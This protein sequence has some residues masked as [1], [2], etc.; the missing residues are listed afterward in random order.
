MNHTQEQSRKLLIIGLDCADPHLVF[1]QFSDLLPVFRSIADRGFAARLRSTDPPLTIPAWATMTT[2]MN[3]GT[4][5]C[6]GLRNRTSYQY[7]SLEISTSQSIHYPRIWNRLAQTGRQSIIVGV[8]QTYPV[9]PMNGTLIAG[10][11]APDIHSQFT[12]PPDLKTD[13]LNR[14]PDYQIDIADFRSIPPEALQSQII[15]M[16]ETRFAALRY[17]LQSR[18]WD[19]A[20]MVEIAL[21]RLHHAFWHY[22]DQTHPLHPGDTALARVLPD[23]YRL[24]NREIEETLAILPDNTDIMIVSDHG[25]QPMRGGFRINEWLRQN[26]Y[27][28]LLTGPTRET[29]LSADMVDWSQTRAWGEGGYF[30]RIFL[31]VAGREPQGIIA[32]AEYETIRQQLASSLKS[33]YEPSEYHCGPGEMM[34]NQVIFPDS[35][36][37]DCNGYPPDMMVYFGE[38]AWRSLS[39]VGPADHTFG[40]GFFTRRNDRGPDGANHNFHGILISSFCDQ[41][42]D[43]DHALPETFQAP[44]NR[45]ILDI[46]SLIRKYYAIH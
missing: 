46:D 32:A 10:M 7:D 2:G 9:Q 8:P 24:L 26:G 36:Y 41:K 13:L 19:F 35:H 18:Q 38:L 39:G 25:A 43:T 22:W 1:D 27:L 5:G 14:F 15:S 17:L 40:N 23:Y 42:Q 44:G 6:Y 37:T 12:W 28:T 16:T 30:G 29:P 20:M 34:R 4:L 3:P 11:L 31:N 45:N 21:D 33:L